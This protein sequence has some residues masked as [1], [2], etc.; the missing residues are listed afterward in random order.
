MDYIT[1]NQPLS[2][3]SL[4]PALNLV[5]TWA[6]D[7]VLASY[8]CVCVCVWGGERQSPQCSGAAVVP[9]TYSVPTIHGAIHCLF[10][11]VHV[12]LIIYLSYLAGWWLVDG[13]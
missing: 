3:P 6:V 7:G 9:S 4:C 11:F 8:V 5:R 12:R 13:R 10:F 1:L 2:P